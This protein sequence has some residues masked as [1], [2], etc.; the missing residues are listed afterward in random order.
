MFSWEEGVA[1][2]WLEKTGEGAGYYVA[3]VYLCR[4]MPAVLTPTGGPNST[5]WPQSWKSPDT[6]CQLLLG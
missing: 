5:S 1:L 3:F 2:G 6:S 4:V